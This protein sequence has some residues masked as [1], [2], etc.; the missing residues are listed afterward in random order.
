MKKMGGGKKKNG[1]RVG[2]GEDVKGGGDGK[3]GKKRRTQKPQKKKKSLG[4]T[5]VGKHKKTKESLSKIQRGINEPTEKE[6]DIVV[7]TWRV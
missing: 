1:V 6:C 4:L 5:Q 7:P 3:G 2:L